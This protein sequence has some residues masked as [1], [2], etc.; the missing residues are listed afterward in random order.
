M[1][2]LDRRQ[3]ERDEMRARIFA[4]AREM[5]AA[6]GPDGV[7]LRKLAERIEY[8]AP[9]LYSYFKDKETLL[10]ELCDEDFRALRDAFGRIEQV[11]DPIE[12]LRAIGHAYL[13]FG[14]EHPQHYLF[15]FM[16]PSPPLAPEDSAIRQG[17]P[18]EDA[19][20]FLHATV[21]QALAAGRFRPEYGDADLVAQL[22]WSSMHG[23]VALHLTHSK[24]P[25]VH[26]RPIEQS[27]RA[28]LDVMLRGLMAPR[29]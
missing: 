20:A 27:A 5:F 6:E 18:D 24:D 2:R 10:R 21:A 12:R 13:E 17:D 22:L 9:A 7:S 11:A 26:W 23:L 1:A 3:R 28:M 15:M 14:L 8:T 16:T 29:E 4:A 25:W 19:Y